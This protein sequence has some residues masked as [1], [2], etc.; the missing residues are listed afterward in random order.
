[1]EADLKSFQPFLPENLPVRNEPVESRFA[2]DL[3]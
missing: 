1:V 2:K 3:P